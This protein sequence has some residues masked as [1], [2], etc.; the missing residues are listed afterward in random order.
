MLSRVK[1]SRSMISEKSGNSATR[2]L[3]MEKKEGK[4]GLGRG[5]ER[6]ERGKNRVKDWGR[7]GKGEGTEE[8][9]T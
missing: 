7:Q 9:S 8:G 4:E 6:K 2:Q 5:A 1:T 3:G